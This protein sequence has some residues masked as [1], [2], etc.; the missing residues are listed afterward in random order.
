MI[1]H[2]DPEEFA[3]L[4][5]KAV[6]LA[7]HPSPRH[8]IQAESINEYINDCPR[9][10]VALKRIKKVRAEHRPLVAA[11]MCRVAL[12]SNHLPWVPI[13]VQLGIALR[14]AGDLDSAEK[15]LRDVLADEPRSRL[16]NSALI[17]LLRDQKRFAEATELAG[18]FFPRRRHRRT[19]GG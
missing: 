2:L 17:R 11:E 6:W 16:A 1:D 13:Q 8:D 4:E 18:E 12:T 9:S 10:R 5:K 3:R 15:A 7:Q 19:V 14:E